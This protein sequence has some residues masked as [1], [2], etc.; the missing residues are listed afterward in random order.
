MTEQGPVLVKETETGV[1]QVTVN[2]PERRNALN[3]EVK[4]LIADAVERLDRDPTVRVCR[5]PREQA[6]PSSQAPTSPRCGH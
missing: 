6:M 1:F 3:I 5:A 4:D 2:R